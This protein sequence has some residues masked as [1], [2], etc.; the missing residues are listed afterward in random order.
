MSITNFGP[1]I[2]YV[3][4]GREDPI[5]LTFRLGLSWNLIDTDV[6]G[7]ILTSD[8]SK[9]LV[10]RGDGGERSPFYQDLF[11]GWNDPWIKD[12]TFSAGGE[13]SFLSVAAGRIGFFYE[14][15]NF[16]ARQFVTYGIAVGPEAARLSLSQFFYSK[17][18]VGG[19]YNQFVL[20][21]TLAR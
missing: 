5:P 9:L 17:H 13:V 16:G 21:F 4:D 7:L 3:E 8:I 1:A 18:I 14:D 20:S 11:T 6:I 10:E 12:L 15:I 19:F 2:S